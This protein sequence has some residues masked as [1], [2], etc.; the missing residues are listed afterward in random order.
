MSEPTSSLGH[1]SRPYGIND[2]SYF[3]PFNSLPDA[4][5]LFL[6]WI[7]LYGTYVLIVQI[8]VLIKSKQTNTWLN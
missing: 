2:Y 5:F 4:T 3:P 8:V 7:F 1:T 6:S